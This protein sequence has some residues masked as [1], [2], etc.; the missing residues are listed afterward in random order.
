MSQDA[1]KYVGSLLGK[2]A[3]A[4]EG[5]VQGLFLSVIGVYICEI[6]PKHIRGKMI[7]LIQLFT[8]STPS[9]RKPFS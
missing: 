5:L 8:A 7:L 4:D 9:L 6:S 1:E 3:N 2:A